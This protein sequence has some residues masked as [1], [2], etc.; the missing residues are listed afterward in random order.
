MLGLFLGEL[1]FGGDYCWK[2]F[3]LANKNSLKHL[4]TAST[5]SP[6][7]YIREGLLSEGYLRPRFRGRIFGRACFGGR[8]G[9]GGLL[10]EFY[11][12]PT[13]VSKE[14]CKEHLKEKNNDEPGDK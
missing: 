4:K 2:K 5:N 7:A 11:G 10:S 1:I 8:G 14:Y 12:I 6:W 9:G 13:N 3:W